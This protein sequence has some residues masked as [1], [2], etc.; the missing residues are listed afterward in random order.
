[1][2]LIL[3]LSLLTSLLSAS[4]RIEHKK[5]CIDNKLFVQTSVMSEFNGHNDWRP[6][7]ASLTQV[8][9]QWGSALAIVTCKSSPL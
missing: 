2:K 1:M 3:L 5:V 7:S 4:S 8:F 9:E 6:I